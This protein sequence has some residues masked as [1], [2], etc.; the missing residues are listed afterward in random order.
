MLPGLGPHAKSGI[1]AKLGHVNLSQTVFQDQ[2]DDTAGLSEHDVVAAL[3]QRF[4]VAEMTAGLA[5]LQQQGLVNTSG[6]KRPLML[7]KNF[8]EHME[9]MQL[10]CCLVAATCTSNLSIC[11]C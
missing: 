5:F 1:P 9:V 10:T 2:A 3:S 8:A 11:M 4:S 6:V 7:S